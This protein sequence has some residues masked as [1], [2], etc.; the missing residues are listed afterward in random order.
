MA[1]IGTAYIQIVPSTKGMS[2]AI[3]RELG[4]TGEKGGREMGGKAS[5]GF[6]KSG[7]MGAVAGVASKAFEKGVGAL[8]SSLDGA[9]RRYDTIQNFPK[10]MENFGIEASEAG[11][12]MEEKLAPALQN[13]PTKLDDAITGVQNFTAK[14]QD[15]DKATDIFVAMNNALLAG[16]K[17]MDIQGNAMEQFSK[18]FATGSLNMMGW[19]SIMSTMPAQMLQVAEALGYGSE[20]VEQLG[21]DLR[22]GIVP[23]EAFA[24]AIVAMNEKGV[25][26]FPSL[27]EQA[28]N[29]TGG[30]G[31]NVSNMKTAVIRGLANMMGKVDKAAESNGFPKI[32][33]VIA[34]T[35]KG[36]DKAFSFIGDIITTVQQKI[37]DFS[38]SDA[39]KRMAETVGRLSDAAAGFGSPGEVFL[40]IIEKIVELFST[41]GLILVTWI[42]GI[43]EGI[44][45]FINSEAG[46]KLKDTFDSIGEKFRQLTEKDGPPLMGFL[47]GLAAVYSTVAQ[48]IGYAVLGIALAID[49]LSTAILFVVENFG[50]FIEAIKGV[51]D[52]GIE[53]VAGAIGTIKDNLYWIAPALGTVTAL[54]IAYK[55]ATIAA[56]TS[57]LIWKGTLLA[58]RIGLKAEA[59]IN[60]ILTGI[61]AAY[62][63]ATGA[64]TAATTAFGVALKFAL[65]P[66]GLIILAIGALI[67]IVILIIKHWD[68]IKGKVT[69]VFGYV[70]D[71]V[72]ARI[73]DVVGFFRGLVSTIKSIGLRVLDFFKELPGK[74]VDFFRQ[75]PNRIAYA[76]GFVIGKIARWVI[77]M[78]IKAAEILP[79][80]IEAVATFFSE[81]PGRIWGFLVEAVTNLAQ[82]IADMSLKAQ[83]V[84]LQ[85]I[86]AIV[87]FFSELPGKI[88]SFLV[89]VV[90]QIGEW[91]AD[92]AAAAKE[93]IPQVIDAIKGWFAE[94][95]GK[96]LLGISA[97]WET[98]K[99]TF[100]DLPG[101]VLDAIEGIKDV[102]KAL[103]EGLWNGITSM[104]KWIIDKIKGFASSLLDGFKSG[105]DSHSP[106]RLTMMIG[107][108]VGSG[109]GI[110]LFD[111]LENVRKNL[112]PE[113]DGLMSEFSGAVNPGIFDS[114]IAV[115]DGVGPI[116]YKQ[117]IINQTV[118]P[119]NTLLDIYNNTKFG[120]RAA[121]TA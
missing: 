12:V 95:P 15:V 8:V 3:N 90:T 110:G 53:T 120:V 40:G 76:L 86:E 104:G 107:S 58:L 97:L 70:K 45:K 61:K 48:G 109:F 35:T 80:V 84:G 39:G 23:M 91:I 85:V 41:A 67:T 43:R 50:P 7:F 19:R 87:T 27:A 1:D 54:I 51:I 68:K 10:V 115:G 4:N 89:G 94:L 47:D 60:G 17:S 93:I 52:S 31:T 71:F 42:D 46:Q 69:E 101:H 121:V 73:N 22:K 98:I 38:N 49:F 102:G 30:I 99:Q 59:T 63:A 28:A 118:Q 117:V 6:L 77:D 65:G 88:W 34:G 119:S 2:D 111:S 29:A 100:L 18:A 32:A 74:I 103:V 105:F 112:R 82:W 75:L 79:K 9:V 11:R 57:G 16:G 5:S 92:T 26:G 96:I 66:V 83:E 78:T 113:L 24:D 37:Q 25:E 21:D 14:T 116:E 81:L 33:D 106:S 62:T 114:N 55:A 13:I 108:D 44:E 72:L 64:A 56:N 20:N 36:I